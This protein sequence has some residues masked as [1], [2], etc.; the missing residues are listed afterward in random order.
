MIFGTNR[1]VSI[2]LPLSCEEEVLPN[3]FIVFFFGFVKSNYVFRPHRKNSFFPLDRKR[4]AI[5]ATQS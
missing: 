4:H 1:D 3:T 5:A 2:L